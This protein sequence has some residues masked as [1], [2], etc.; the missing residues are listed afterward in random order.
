MGKSCSLAELNK[1]MKNTLMDTDEEGF[2]ALF[3]ARYGYERLEVPF[4]YTADFVID[5]DIDKIY[6]VR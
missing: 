4:V 2:A 5:L 1:R 3:C 6:R